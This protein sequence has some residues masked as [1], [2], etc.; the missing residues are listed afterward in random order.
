MIFLLFLLFVIASL[1]LGSVYLG[2]A[3]FRVW[4]TV[5]MLFILLHQ[6]IIKGIKVFTSLNTGVILVY[7]LFLLSLLFSLTFN[8]EIT[9]YGFVKR[10][11]AYYFVCIISYFAVGCFVP[12]KNKIHILIW[13]LVLIATFNNLVAILQFSGNPIGWNI[14]GFFGDVTKGE[15]FSDQHADIIGYSVIPGVFGDSVM[16][17]FFTAIVFPL[18]F[19]IISNRKTFLSLCVFLLFAAINVYGCF[20]TQQRISFVLV[21]FSLLL[22]SVKYVKTHPFLS[23]F[24]VLIVLAFS[25]FAISE[26]EALNWGRLFSSENDARVRLQKEAIAFIIEHPFFGG[27]VSFQ[28][29]AGMSS[30]NVFLDSFIHA[31]IGGGVSIIILWVWSIVIAIK[32]IARGLFSKASQTTFALAI[33]FFNTMLYGLWHTTSYLTGY[34]IIFIILALLLRSILLDQ[35]HNSSK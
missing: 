20:V 5:L 18:L 4:T 17:G 32:S 34:N 8:G 24:A 15:E 16:S 29:R 19:A 10:L 6:R 31:G 21:V 33:A 35:S 7:C 30:H 14:G 1:L 9:E 11:L 3:S 23:L 13:V 27:P 26:F 22:V 25:G 2:P 12:D 28:Q